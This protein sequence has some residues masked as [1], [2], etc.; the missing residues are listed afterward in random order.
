M[1]S[2]RL[3]RFF[4]SVGFLVALGGCD[5]DPAPDLDAGPDATAGADAG[6]GEP[7]SGVVDSGAVD[8]TVGIDSGTADAGVDPCSSPTLPTL[9]TEL[10]EAP[11]GDDWDAPL[12]LT[13][14]PG[15]DD[16]YIVQRGGRVRR[17]APD[18]SVSDFVDI[19]AQVQAGGERGLLGLAFHPAY[20]SNGRFF[21][22]YTANSTTAFASH[23]HVGEFQRLDAT[24]GDPVE[25]R[26]LVSVDDPE[27]NHNGGMIA[28][29]PDGYL[30]VG[31]GD[32]GGAND[33]HGANGNGLNREVL[34]GKLLRLDVDNV[35]GDFV[36]TSNPFVGESGDDHIWAYGLR[37]PW[38]FSF[39]RATGDL[40]IGD[41]GQNRFEEIS[42]QSAA[43]AGG[44][45]YGWRAYEGFERLGSSTASDLALVPVHTEPLV[46]YPHERVTPISGQAVVG[47][48]VYRGSAIPALRGWYLFADTYSGDAA[49]MV[50]CEGAATGLQAARGIS[51]GFITSFGEGPDGELYQIGFD[52]VRRI[53]GG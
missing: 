47:G 42:F 5:D 4:F 40:Y 21:M 32:G 27:S 19:S 36:A 44:E 46:V 2:E 50:V 26:S 7:D 31:M 13:Y 48:Y 18:G 53:I 35:A 6:S 34:F 30:Y 38:R 29:G 25:V 45:N 37:N 1:S 11:S 14:A 23:V 9:R 51:G 22:F 12:F 20:A 10:I 8:A 49:A 15:A 41:V 39:D 16:L 3:V 33:R 43:S 52:F 28:F 24:T 17:V